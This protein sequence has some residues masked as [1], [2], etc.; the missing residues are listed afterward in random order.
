M[1]LLLDATHR[2]E[3]RHFWFRGLRRFL[4]PLLRHATAGR[5]NARILDCGC[6][7][8]V[9]LPLFAR[10]GTVWAVDLN[11]FGLGL[12]RQ[13]GFTRCARA[14]VASLPFPDACFDVVTSIDVLY[15]L[16][17]GDERVAVDEMFRVLEPGGFAVLN[18]AAMR[19]L[20]GSH[21]VLAQEVRRYQRADARALL[22]R[23]GFVIERLTYTNATLFPLVLGQRVLERLLGLASPHEAAAQLRVPAAP[24]NALMTAL[25]A[26]ESAWLRVLPAPFGSSLLCLAKKRKTPA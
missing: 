23:A 2:V 15:S 22:E 25:L 18:L 6:G 13:A 20:R 19:I 14:T 17:D 4:A 5:L 8:G 10:Y 11:R 9:N 12:A 1:D 26:V 3:A 24:L 7:T 21:S 16:S